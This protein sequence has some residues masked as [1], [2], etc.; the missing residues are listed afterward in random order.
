[1]SHETLEWRMTHSFWGTFVFSVDL[2][3][4]SS[5]SHIHTRKPKCIESYKGKI[6]IDYPNAL[7]EF[8]PHL[9]QPKNRIAKCKSCFRFCSSHV[10]IEQCASR[11]IRPSVD[12]QKVQLFNPRTNLI[13]TSHF[14]FNKYNLVA[15]RKLLHGSLPY[16][17]ATMETEFIDTAIY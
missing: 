11:A 3:H 6:Y 10:Y 1:M 16:R 17:K 5:I 2:Y 9:S 8:Y 14:R 7:T 15:F 12:G 4:T 13:K